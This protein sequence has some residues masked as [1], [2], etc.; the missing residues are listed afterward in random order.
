MGMRWY[1][2]FLLHMTQNNIVKFGTPYVKHLVYLSTGLW[3]TS[4]TNWSKNFRRI[5]YVYVQYTLK[6]VGWVAQSA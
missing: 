3:M 4:V 5:R 2:I 6:C 1:R